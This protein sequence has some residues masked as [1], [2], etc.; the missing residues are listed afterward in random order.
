MY[1]ILT[2]KEEKYDKLGIMQKLV[3]GK[4]YTWKN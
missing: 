1:F 4:F 3:L 2:M